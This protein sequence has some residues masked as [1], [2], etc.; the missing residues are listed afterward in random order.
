M[1]FT[2]EYRD[3]TADIA[4]MFQ[5]TSAEPEGSEAG[6]V[7][8]PALPTGPPSARSNA[9][10]PWTHRFPEGRLPAGPA[11]DLRR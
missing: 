11:C 10:P 8:D 1:E 4:A 3:G 2:T 9:A 6:H 7:I 5:E